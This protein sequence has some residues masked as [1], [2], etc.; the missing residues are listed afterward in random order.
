M[1]WTNGFLS[2]MNGGLSLGNLMENLDFWSRTSG[3]WINLLAIT[4]GTT[5]GLLVKEKLP[6]RMQAVMMQAVGLLTIFVGLTLAQDMLGVEA[7]AVDGVVL[8][9]VALVLGGLLGEWLNLERRLEQIGNGLKRR[10]RG[11]GKFTEGFVAASLLFC[12]GPMAL[13]GSLNN[14]LQGDDTLLVL[15]A[16]MDG[17]ASVALTV[18]YGVGVAG[19]LLSILVYQ[20]GLS[21]VAGALA[22]ALPDPAQDP[23]VLLATGVGGLMI[24]AIGLNLLEMARVQ[25]ASFLPALAIAPLIFMLLS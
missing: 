19:S 21:L 1:G 3:T 18:S 17:I 16:T 10:L 13:I 25:V 20:G 23:R 22:Q 24:L 4:L 15:K 9:L 2:R 8:G 7:G 12:V 11:K 6:P 14:G 5:V